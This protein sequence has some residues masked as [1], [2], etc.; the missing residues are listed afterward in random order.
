M[1]PCAC[2]PGLVLDVGTDLGTVT[3]VLDVEADVTLDG[4]DGMDG[5]AV[6]ADFALPIDDG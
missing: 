5:P 4:L 3:E 6:V 2:E 1:T